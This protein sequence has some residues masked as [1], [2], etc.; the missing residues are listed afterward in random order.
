MVVFKYTLR[1]GALVLQLPKGAQILYVGSQERRLRLWALVDRSAPT[2]ART[3]IV[4]NTGDEFAASGKVRHVGT[5][6][7]DADYVYHVFEEVAH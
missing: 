1:H 5:I 2:E 7:D 6:Q 4:V 3:F